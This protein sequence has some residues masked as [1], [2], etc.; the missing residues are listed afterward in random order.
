MREL[1]RFVARAEGRSIEEVEVAVV[2]RRRMATLN[3]KHLGRREVTDVLS[4]DLGTGPAGGICAQVVVCSDAAAAAGRRRGHAAWKELLLYV[5]HG[6][7]HVLDYED[8]TPP[9]ARRMHAREDDLL[10]AMGVGRVYGDG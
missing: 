10:E 6:L 9:G 1:V 4:F 3:E 5:A 7:L 2:G 8:A